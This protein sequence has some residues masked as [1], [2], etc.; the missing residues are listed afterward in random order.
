VDEARDIKTV[1]SL[2]IPKAIDLVKNDMPKINSEKDALTTLTGTVKEVKAGNKAMTQTIEAKCITT[3]T[4]TE[5]SESTTVK[6]SYTFSWMDINP[7]MLK[8]EVTSDKMYIDLTALDKNK[9]ITNFKNDKLDGYEQEMRIFAENIEVARRMKFSIEKTI[10]KCKAVYKEPFA[11]NSA[12]TMVNWV[13]TKIG[14]VVVEG[15][16]VKQTFE[17][18]EAS[19]PN[20]IKLTSTEV[21][22]NTSVEEVYEF[23]LSD[24]S[25]AS[26]DF[27]V[28]GKWIY[29]GMESNFKNKIIKYYKNGKIQPYV[30]RID[31]AVTDIETARGIISAQKKSAD[32]LKAK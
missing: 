18:V 27:D 28:K 23:N 22:S 14:E 7:N 24:I 11:T 31:V 26:V 1:L 19:D 6:N 13:K 25:S 5:Q 4:R 21:K 16:S 20:K 15:V 17:P 30:N 32:V 8:I 9:L 29:V 10:E 2:A 12:T 3:V